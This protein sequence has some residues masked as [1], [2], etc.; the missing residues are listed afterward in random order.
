MKSIAV[1]HFIY[2]PVPKK[3]YSK[4]AVSPDI[5][6]EEYEHLLGSYIPVDPTYLRTGDVSNHEA[7]IIASVPQNDCIYFSRIFRRPRLDE[8]GRTG[9]LTHTVLLPRKEL[10]N[11]LSYN[12]VEE[13]LKNFEVMNPEIKIGNMPLLEISWEKQASELM[14]MKSLISKDSLTRLAEG[15][16]KEPNL[17]YA[18]TCKGM[19]PPQRMELGYALSRFFDIEL[20]LVPISL[21]TEPPLTIANSPFNLVL[22]HMKMPIPPRIGWNVIS[23]HAGS[24]LSGMS[25]SSKEVMKKAIDDLFSLRQ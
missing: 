19:E 10:E 2:G 11:G 20:K 14:K 16:T 21:I 18:V 17:K 4:R 13:A 5:Y 15:F 22:S 6:P 7:R 8:K 3:G 23:T 25:A 12:D 9:I 1:P 24:E